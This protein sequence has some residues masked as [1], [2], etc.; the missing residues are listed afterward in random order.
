MAARR[1]LF[2]ERHLWVTPNMRDPDA[3]A[4]VDGGQA[5]CAGP[6]RA[7]PD[8]DVVREEL[9]GAQSGQRRDLLCET[10]QPL[11]S[12]HPETVNAGG[13]SRTAA[14]RTTMRFTA[15]ALGAVGARTPARSGARPARLR[16]RAL[17]DGASPG[18][19]ARNGVCF[20]PRIV[21]WKRPPSVVGVL[22]V[23]V[24]TLARPRNGLRPWMP[25]PT[26]TLTWAGPAS[27]AA[28]GSVR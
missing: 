23:A 9:P 5:E 10:D 8:A 18:S 15:A 3:A 12:R 28:C 24:T 25:T 16:G 26:I 17:A 20:G 1:P 21:A 4:T 11:R 13:A 2:R 7:T 27:V 19:V 6:D 22:L 14:A